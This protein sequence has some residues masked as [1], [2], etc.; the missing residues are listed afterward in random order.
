MKQVS[1]RP[2]QPVRYTTLNLLFLGLLCLGIPLAARAQLVP[3]PSPYTTAIYTTN[4]LFIEAEDAD[5]NHGS[6]VTTTN[7]G[8]D[9]PY[10]GGSYTNLGTTTDLDFDWLAQSSTAPNSQVY[11]ITTFLSGGK[12]KGTAGSDRGTFQVKDWWTLGWNSSGDWENYT[13]N[14]PATPQNYF[15][16][17]HAASGG[18]NVTLELD[19]V[20][21]GFGL[22]DTMQVKQPLGYI[23]PGRATAGWDSMEIFP[24]TDTNGN[25]ITINL[26]GSNT[27]RMVCMTNAGGAPDLDYYAFVPA[28]VPLFSVNAATRDQA[29]AVIVDVPGTPGITVDATTISLTLNGSTVSGTTVK[30]NGVTTIVIAISP[31]AVQGA[32]NTLAAAY[33]DTTAKSYNSSAKFVVN[34]F[35]THATKF[36]EFE[37]ADYN[38]GQWVTTTNIGLDGVYP[39]G[40]YTNLGTLADAEFDWHVGG[41]H[42]PPADG[43]TY[44]SSTSLS[45]GKMN[46]SAG[47]DRAYFQVQN[48]WTVGWN[49]SGDWGNYT[50]QFPT[51]T[52]QWYEGYAHLASGGG[53][54]DIRLEQVTSG[55]GQAN[56]NQTTKVLGYFSPGRATASWDSMEVFP[57]LN[58]DF[59]NGKPTVIKLSGL[60][61]LKEFQVGTEDI[62]YMAFVP[63]TLPAATITINSQP[64]SVTIPQGGFASFSVAASTTGNYGLT[65]QWNRN[66]TPINGAI[67]TTYR[68]LSAALT[69]SGAQFTATVSSPGAPSVNSQ[70]AVLTVVN[71]TN[72]PVVVSAGSLNVRGAGP[73]V[74]VIFNKQMTGADLANAAN[75]TLDN[76][77]TVSSARYLTNSSGFTTFL[78]DG[79]AIPN[80][81]QGAILQVSALT[82]STAYH[83]TVKNVHDYLNNLLTSQTM[84]VAQSPFTLVTMG[85]VTTNTANPNGVDDEA[86]A[87]DTNSF[88]LVNGG[89]AFWGTED[90]ITMVYEKITGDFDKTT[91]VEWNDPS[92]NW[93]RSGISAREDADPTNALAT[94]P[95]GSVGVPPRYQMIISDPFTKFDGT[96]ANDQ[97][98]TNRRLNPGDTTSNNNGGGNPH[99]PGSFVRLKRVGD[100]ISMFYSK[101]GLSWITNC[102][103]DFGTNTTAITTTNG[104]AADLYV[105]PTLGVENGNILGQ[106][107]TIDQTGNFASRFRNY[108][109]MFQKA[110]GKQTY[111]VGLKLGAN[112]GGS[113][114]SPADV[115]GA[116]QVAQ[117]DWNNIFS[118]A[119]VN[120][121]GIV[122]DQAGAAVATPIIVSVNGCPNTW[123]SEGLGNHSDSP[124]GTVGLM[125]GNDQVMMTGYLDSGAASTTQVIITGIPTAL[126]SGGYDVVVYATG[127]T[128]GRGGGYRVADAATNTIQG[129]YKIQGPV[130][131]TNLIQAIPDTTGATWAVGN[132]VVFTNITANSIVVEG[133]TENGFGFGALFRA[134]VN[135]IQLV[136]P[137]GLIGGGPLPGPTIS[138]A[139]SGGN[140]VIT[141]SGTLYSASTVNGTYG[142]V[143]GAS[144]PYTIPI[145]AAG[146]QFYRAHNP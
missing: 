146:M 37:D 132:F 69:D 8:M 59:P 134:P 116:D 76:G 111:A 70:A 10:P 40:S 67:S 71:D 9:G 65:Y 140:W 118:N 92:S 112:E 130:N 31:L 100:L 24:M 13:R 96:G 26:S 58:T 115:A 88:N 64:Q 7:I 75:F 15:V 14:F 4:T 30:T 50:R 123:A 125:S 74:A 94:F 45:A 34:T 68:V 141:Y 51:D 33:K 39:G 144:S 2:A 124:Y 43:T 93:A 6:F 87:V 63:V 95:D 143:A 17:A 66:G 62:D 5:F 108:G 23:L 82:P 57:L 3:Y 105:G 90:D 102:T 137:S 127:G 42:V 128:G 27:L 41:T 22:D 18:P 85:L 89:N 16:F 35:I 117:A 136:A 61:T 129:Y 139:Q 99:Y 91:Q 79:T 86:L 46:G 131:A 81:Q 103:T 138:V 21:S 78:P 109:N 20:T 101:N 47:N 142:P 72:P 119:P 114:L 54:I 55:F 28:T 84:A 106:G 104:L 135:A 113:Q 19:K 98:E 121:T 29:T 80:R 97:Y 77:A 73:Q 83:L 49:S 38:H 107:G 53:N 60:V 56:S 145:S 133:T 48:W 32:T 11:R 1:T 120:V 44:R 12:E 52:N 36:I 126:T 25:I 110:N 122:A